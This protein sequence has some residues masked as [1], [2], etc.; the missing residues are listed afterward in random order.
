MILESPIKLPFS[1]AAGEVGS[2]FLVAL[3]DNQ[4]VLGV[5]CATCSTVTAPVRPF[6]SS[7]SRAVTEL[8]EVGPG[9]TLEAWTAQPGTGI[10][11]LV[12][13]DGADTALV[14]RLIGD[15]EWRPGIRVRA[16]FADER[17][18]HITD[19]EG[20]IAERVGT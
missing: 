20:F 17:T 6:C 10:F 15:G 3:R 2:R 1:Y 16:V 4:I 5:R 9:G 12:R 11:G 7:C 13:L 19:I 14:H 8:V 18:A